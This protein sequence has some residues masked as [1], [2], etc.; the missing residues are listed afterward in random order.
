VSNGLSL[1]S[2]HHRAFDEDLVGVA[3]DLRVHVS[4]RLL[5]DEDGPML[6]VLK[7]FHGTT[8]DTPAKRLWRPDP[9][10][11]ETRFARFQSAG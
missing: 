9:N 6:D 8:I 2:I 5:D 4:S 11:L 10:R 3:P 1:C 7:G